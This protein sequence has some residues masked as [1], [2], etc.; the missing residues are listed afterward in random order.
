MTLPLSILG[1]VI[2]F[3]IAD[4]Y[5]LD[6]PEFQDDKHHAVFQKYTESGQ[7]RQWDHFEAPYRH[8]DGCV[9]YRIRLA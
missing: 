9:I 1:G 6:D 3:N 4:K 2:V 7:W 8:S 5:L